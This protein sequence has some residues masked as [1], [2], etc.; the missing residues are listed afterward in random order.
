VSPGTIVTNA[1]IALSPQFGLTAGGLQAPYTATVVDDWADRFLVRGGMLR[2]TI[3]NPSQTLSAT[4]TSI[5]VKIYMAW[6]RYVAPASVT[7]M[8]IG[9]GASNM[10]DPTVVYNWFTTI[11]APRMVCE[12]VL[13]PGDAVVIE[14]KLPSFIYKQAQDQRAGLYAFP[15]WIYSIESLNAT[16]T[17]GYSATYGY[18]LSFTGDLNNITY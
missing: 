15:Y 7:T 11:K 16:A 14:K 1:A 8:F 18:S 3:T 2:L 5:R 9:T 6:S 13:I 17:N 12:K 4:D 10:W